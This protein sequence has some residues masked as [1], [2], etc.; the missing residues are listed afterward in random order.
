[1]KWRTKVTHEVYVHACSKNEIRVCTLAIIFVFFAAGL[2]SSD[3]SKPACSRFFSSIVFLALRTLIL[4]TP[5]LCLERA[6]CVALLG[7][8]LP[9]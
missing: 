5:S 9:I 6:M 1:M 3:P 2:C 8:V 7:T 4:V